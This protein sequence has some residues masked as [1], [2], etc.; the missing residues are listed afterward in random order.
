MV[1][2]ITNAFSLNMLKNP[3]EATIHIS[4]IDIEQVKE[5]LSGEFI[6]AI[7]HESTA[8][9][10]SE[11]LGVEIKPNR[12]QIKVEYGDDLVVFQLMTR[13]PEGKVLSVEELQQL[14]E[15]GEAKFY[16]VEIVEG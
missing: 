11:L 10:L 16:Y 5:L 15:K 14:I 12:I 13:I 6:S 1:L 3:S 9:V 2:Y 7:G 8:K 4:E